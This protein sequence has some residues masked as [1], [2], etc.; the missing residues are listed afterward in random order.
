[1]TVA[2]RL[3]SLAYLGTAAEERPAQ[4]DIVVHARSAA[5]RQPAPNPAAHPTALGRSSN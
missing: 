5:H 2:F 1:M 4:H 3:C